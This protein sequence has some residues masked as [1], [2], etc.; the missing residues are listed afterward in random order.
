MLNS[1]SYKTEMISKVQQWMEDYENGSATTDMLEGMAE[2][3]HQS[4]RLANIDTE[5]VAE[6]ID[7]YAQTMDL[8]DLLAAM[9]ALEEEVEAA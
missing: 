2:T 8:A 1:N 5:P 3:L 6:L 4:A 9:K 7:V